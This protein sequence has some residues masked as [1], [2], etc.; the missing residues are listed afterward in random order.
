MR[1]EVE[2]GYRCVGCLKGFH[3][4]CL[5]KHRDLTQTQIVYHRRQCIHEP[6]CGWCG[7]KS[8]QASPAPTHPIVEDRMG[9]C[10]WT[11][12]D[13][14]QKRTALG[15][16]SSWLVVCAPLPSPLCSGFALDLG[17]QNEGHR[18]G[19]PWG[20]GGPHMPRTTKGARISHSKAI[21][22]FLWDPLWVRI[23]SSS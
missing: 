13:G 2:V 22:F 12:F 17:F 21:D 14:Q 20:P 19:L 10:G 9:V 8:L 3:V 4:R 16:R 7:A 1:C 18:R 5:R 6:M 11:C 15:A 23:S